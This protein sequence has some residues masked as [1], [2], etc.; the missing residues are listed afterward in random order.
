[1]WVRPWLSSERQLRLRHFDQLLEE[2]LRRTLLPQLHSHRTGHVSQGTDESGTQ[3]H[4]AVYQLATSIGSY[5]EACIHPPFS[6][7]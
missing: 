3:N 4:Q 5:F 1:M 2:L 6:C 7:H